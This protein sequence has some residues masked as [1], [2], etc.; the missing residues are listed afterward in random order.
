MK[1][2]SSTPDLMTLKVK[3]RLPKWD[4]R[5]LQYRGDKGRDE[6]WKSQVTRAHVDFSHKA[7][8]P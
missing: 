7:M 5:Y 6:L 2:L 8:Y 3:I 1:S 4:E